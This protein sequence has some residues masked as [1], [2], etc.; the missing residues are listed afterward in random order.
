MS[1]Q[2]LLEMAVAADPDRLIVG[3]RECGLTTAE[4]D[5]SAA[6]GAA[7]LK[8]S[9]AQSV[10]YL[11][12][13][14]KEFAVSLFAAAYAGLPF[15]PLN[16]RLAP[17]QLRELISES[18]TPTVLFDEQYADIAA[19]ASVTWPTST[20]ITRATEADPALHQEI[21]DLS[22][23]VVLY[24]SG[25]TSRPKRAILRHGNLLSYVLQTVELGAAKPDDGILVSVPPYHVAGVGSLLTNVYAGRRLV[26]L[27]NFTAQEWLRTVAQENITNAMVVPT[28]LARI[29][30]ELAGRQAATPTLRSIAYGGARTPRPVLEAALAAF[31]DAGFT[32]AY[33]LTESSSTIMLFGPEDHRTAVSSSD[34]M[35]T[36]RLGSVGRPVPGVDIEIRDAEGR[37]LEAGDIGEL[38]VRGAQVSGEYEGMDSSLDS[39]G[40]FCTRDRAWIDADGYVFISG[41]TDDV[42]IKGGENIAPAEIEDVLAEHTDVEDVAVIGVPDDHWGMVIVAAV[43]VRRG[44]APEEEQ[45]REWVRARLRSSRTPDAIWFRTEL[46]YTPTG[47]VLRRQLLTEYCSDQSAQTGAKQ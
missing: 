43:V 31:P 41:R 20:W 17:T 28:M 46:P 23:A 47:K 40:W 22:P 5:R 11:G 39:D 19:A 10:C 37:T 3:T 16:Y 15:T 30:D 4:L 32:N 36:L 13:S 14:S 38:W 24:T 21:D 34:P 12:V 25:T 9:G 2:M 42:I 7:L 45:L 18:P 35:V 44:S 27:P 29:V 26:Y 8:A 6:G 33:G 1:V